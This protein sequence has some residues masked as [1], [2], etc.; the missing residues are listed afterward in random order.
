MDRAGG[1]GRVV[2]DA[3]YISS[4]RK[5]FG[6]NMVRLFQCATNTEYYR[7]HRINPPDNTLSCSSGYA[8]GLLLLAFL[9][10]SAIPR[11]CHRIWTPNS[12]VNWIMCGVDLFVFILV[13]LIMGTSLQASPLSQVEDVGCGNRELGVE[14]QAAD[15]SEVEQQ[16]ADLNVAGDEQHAETE[17]NRDQDVEH[18]TTGLDGTGRKT[19]TGSTGSSQSSPESKVESDDQRGATD[20][21]AADDDAATRQGQQAVELDDQ[22]GVVW[23]SATD[24]GSSVSGALTPMLMPSPDQKKWP[25]AARVV[26][27]LLLLM[28]LLLT[29]GW[30][31]TRE[32]KHEELQITVV[33]NHS[34]R[35]VL[36][37]QL[38]LPP[39]QISEVDLALQ[40]TIDEN[41]AAV[42]ITIVEKDLCREVLTSE[43]WSPLQHVENDVALQMSV[44]EN[45]LCREVLTSQLWLLL[46][47][48]TVS[49]PNVPV[50]LNV[51]GFVF[52]LAACIQRASA[53]T[54]A[55]EDTTTDDDAG[56]PL[57]S[58]AATDEP[59]NDDAGSQLSSDSATTE[60]QGGPLADSRTGK[61]PVPPMESN[62]RAISH[63]C[64]AIVVLPLSTAVNPCQQ[65]GA[66]GDD[67]QNETE[68]AETPG[69]PNSSVSSEDD[70]DSAD[71]AVESEGTSTDGQQCVE[72]ESGDE[73]AED[74]DSEPDDSVHQGGQTFAS[75]VEVSLPSAAVNVLGDV[76]Q[77]VTESVETPGSPNSSVSL[78]GDMDIVDVSFESEGTSDDGQQRV[79]NESGDAVAEDCDNEPDDSVFRGGQTFTPDHVSHGQKRQ[80]DDLPVVANRGDVGKP[81]ALCQQDVV[82]AQKQRD[83]KTEGTER[84]EKF[85]KNPDL[86]KKWRRGRHDEVIAN[87]IDYVRDEMKGH[88][89]TPN[90]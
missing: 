31:M 75:A 56:S 23:S 45:D 8:V 73:V 53:S 66:Q 29:F 63:Q 28:A 90:F 14:Q 42:Q 9:L 57:S 3:K 79:E 12:E 36:T 77:N 4:C 60:E 65:T 59:V 81:R 52:C 35:E 37:F 84:Y 70:I 21:N 50:W 58:D 72:N 16:V 51:A 62:S 13:S 88:F 48:S 18:N 33:D 41:D 20:S 89:V 49:K 2:H 40:M 27:V 61:S 43:S 68:S 47:P 64:P 71:S 44:D 25:S 30:S 17:S 76:P 19:Q 67:P 22:H 55:H 1:G 46:Q 6:D 5:V 11:W 38:W 85:T 86:V 26:A 82:C 7:S 78:E 39:S 83:R 74:C 10:L 54:A 15:S 32:T 24:L 69:S 80:Q 34:C 87:V